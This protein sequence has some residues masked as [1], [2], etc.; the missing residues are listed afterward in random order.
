MYMHFF[1]L[2]QFLSLYSL[3][4]FVFFSLDCVCNNFVKFDFHC[5]SCVSFIVQLFSSFISFFIYYCFIIVVVVCT[6]LLKNR[7]PNG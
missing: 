3:C 5:S 6:D 7:E 2:L 1:L 4:K